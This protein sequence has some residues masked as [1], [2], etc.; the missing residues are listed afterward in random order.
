MGDAA[1]AHVGDVQQAVHAVE[2]DERTEI[3]DVLDRCPCGCWPGWIVSRSSRRLLRALLLDEFA[4]GEND[5]L[6]VEVDL[7]DL[8]VVGLADVLVEILRGLDVDVRSRQERVDADADDQA[9][10]DLGLDAT[11]DDRAFLTLGEDVFPV[12]LL[13]GLV[14]GDNRIAFPVFELFEKDFDL[15][16]DLEFAQIDEFI[17]GD[18]A[19]GLAP[20]STTTSFWRISV[21]MPLMI[22]PSMRFSNWLWASS[23][24]ITDDIGCFS[25]FRRSFRVGEF[26]KTG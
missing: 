24:S 12:L 19:F 20:I 9:A 25:P 1:P 7:E 17:G 15:L 18:K 14:E 11:G 13:L 6:P 26:R 4:A 22:E 5:V 10:L 23:S 3:G 16:A 8:E 2:V 21:M